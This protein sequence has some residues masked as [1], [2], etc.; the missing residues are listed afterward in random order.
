MSPENPHEVLACSKT[1]S[2]S[3]LAR[4][5]ILIDF[6]FRFAT[7]ASGAATSMAGNWNVPFLNSLIGAPPKCSV[8]Y[9]LE[10]LQG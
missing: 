5:S 6:P 8:W 4:T 9:V 10:L 2:T 1:P 7:I 3:I